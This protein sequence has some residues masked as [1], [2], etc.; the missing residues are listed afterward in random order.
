[1]IFC[2]SG[3]VKAKSIKYECELKLI[4]GER[5]LQWNEYS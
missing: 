4:N 2:V 5:K 1:M 3:I